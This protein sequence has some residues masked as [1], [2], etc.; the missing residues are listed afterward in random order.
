MSRAEF[1][2]A[3]QSAPVRPSPQDHA[4]FIWRADGRYPRAEAVH[5]YRNESTAQRAAD[6][7]NETDCKYVVRPLDREG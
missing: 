3:Y 4:V 5:V 1:R 6:R 2:R 7:L